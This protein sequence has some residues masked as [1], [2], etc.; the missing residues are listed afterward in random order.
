MLVLQQTATPPQ[1]NRYCT[2]CANTS[3]AVA[4]L[5][6]TLDDHLADL[7]H[8]AG[9]SPLIV[10]P[11]VYLHHLAVHHHRRQG[12]HN[13]RVW[14]IHKVHRHEGLRLHLNTPHQPSRSATPGAARRQGASSGSDSPHA[15]GY[16]TAAAL[17]QAAALGH[18]P[19][20]ALI[21]QHACHDTRAAGMPYYTQASAVPQAPPGGPTSWRETTRNRR[22]HC[23]SG[24]RLPEA[25]QCR[26]GYTTP[27]C[28]YMRQHDTML[29]LHA[30]TCHDA[31]DDGYVA[32]RIG[33]LGG[34]LPRQH[35]QKRTLRMF[36]R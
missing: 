4:P 32:T 25:S 27:C 23:P 33:G 6:E 2:C 5:S 34:A 8:A 26:R 30:A 1:S 15:H 10:V 20:Q 35:G 13:G 19:V 17:L 12:I 18:H 11:C 31:H 14:V 28:G 16:Q 22:T 29:W 7:C 3:E 9:V 24:R 21:P 36:F